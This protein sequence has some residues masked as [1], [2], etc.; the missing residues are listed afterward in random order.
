MIAADHSRSFFPG[1]DTAEE[2]LLKQMKEETKWIRK[3]TLS[4]A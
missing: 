1:P 3:C 2:D 4:Q